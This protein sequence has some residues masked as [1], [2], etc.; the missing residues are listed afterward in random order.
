MTNLSKDLRASLAEQCASPFLRWSE[1]RSPLRMGPSSILWR[2]S[3]VK[4]HRNGFE[5]ATNHG[6]YSLGL[7]PGGVPDGMRLL[8]FHAGWKG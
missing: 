3:D 7:L 2:L 1:N 5:C 4:W 8:C 6:Q